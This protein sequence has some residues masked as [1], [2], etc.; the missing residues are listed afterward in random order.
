MHIVLVLMAKF[1]LVSIPEEKVEV[2]L[3]F[4]C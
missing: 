2:V 1:I 4:L 3:Q